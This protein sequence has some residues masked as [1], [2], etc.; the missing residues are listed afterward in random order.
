MNIPTV[1][2]RDGN[3]I[4]NTF[5][6]THVINPYIA[7]Q[8]KRVQSAKAYDAVIGEIKEHIILLTDELSANDFIDRID[9]FEH[10]GNSRATVQFSDFLNKIQADANVEFGIRLPSPDDL[11]WGEF[12]AYYKNFI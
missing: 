10:A 7:N 3:A 2:D 1:V 8:Q 12:E 11:Y 4:A 5:C 9:T 6:Q